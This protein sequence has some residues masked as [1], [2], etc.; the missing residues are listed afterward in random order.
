MI[1]ID[2]NNYKIVKVPEEAPDKNTVYDSTV[3][4][5]SEQHVSGSL[6][7]VHTGY[8]AW[9]IVNENKH[10]NTKKN[11]DRLVKAITARGTDKYVVTKYDLATSDAADKSVTVY[12]DFSIGDYANQVGRQYIVNMNLCRKYED[13][14]I[15]DSARIVGRYY[16]NKQKTKEVVV[17]QIPDGYR[18]S[19][20]PKAA[21][22]GA[23]GLWNYS[24][25][26]KADK[27]SVTLTKE[28][29][30]NTLCI[31]PEQFNTNNKLVD[32]VKKLYRESVVLTAKK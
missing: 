9:N 29:T 22:G 27:N 23:D 12:A 21:K 19:Y 17:L 13:M 16:S 4:R 30:F 32:E 6:A 14:R 15:A 31:T 3:I 25:S 20:L 8:D 18:V 10:N 28:Y 2:A 7:R 26:Y 5:L 24:I 1:A 11:R